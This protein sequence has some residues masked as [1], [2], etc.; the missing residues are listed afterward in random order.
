MDQ[1]HGIPPNARHDLCQKCPRSSEGVVRGQNR[2]LLKQLRATSTAQ[3]PRGEGSL[4]LEDTLLSSY[5]AFRPPVKGGN[6]SPPTHEGVLPAWHGRR[7]GGQVRQSP[8]GQMVVVVEVRTQKW[9]KMVG[10]GGVFRFEMPPK[11]PKQA[12]CGSLRVDFLPSVGG[13]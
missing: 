11:L 9:F 6:F 13:Y 8:G 4:L 2:V 10:A 5:E 1:E 3:D 12:V 7:P